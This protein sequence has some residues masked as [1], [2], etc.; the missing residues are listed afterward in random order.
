MQVLEQVFVTETDVLK[1]YFIYMIE[2]VNGRYYTDYTVD[3][4]R[5]YN[6]H[7]EDSA[8]KTVVVLLYYGL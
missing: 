1:D 3:I 2:S 6:K 8:S 4:K 5:R 7:C